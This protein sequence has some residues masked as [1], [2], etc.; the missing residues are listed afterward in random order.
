MNRLKNRNFFEIVGETIDRDLIQ[1]SSKIIEYLLNTG[2]D[3]VKETYK[4][5]SD[6]VSGGGV[7]VI[8]K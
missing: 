2:S 8:D 4:I 6:A 3:V 7:D 1:P 5:G